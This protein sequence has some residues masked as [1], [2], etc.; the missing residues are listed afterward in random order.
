[1]D[2]IELLHCDC[3]T[4]MKDQ[5]D[6]SFD[7][8]I[9]DPPYMENINGYLGMQRRMRGVTDTKVY[10]NS[11]YFSKPK[12]YYFDELFRISKNQIIWCINH[13]K[14]YFGC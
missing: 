11:P 3:M 8:A 6:N 5:P 12:N 10:N 1:M 14:Y 4:Y 7:L 9:V 13:Y 2:K